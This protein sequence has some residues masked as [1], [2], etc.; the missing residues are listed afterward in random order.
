M[1]GQDATTTGLVIGAKGSNYQTGGSV[2]VEAAAG[3]YT[4]SVQFSATSGSVTVRSR[5]LWVE[6]KGF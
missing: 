6:A 5:K 2:R 1:E 4:V 3:T